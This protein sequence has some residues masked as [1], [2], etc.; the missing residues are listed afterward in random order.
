MQCDFTFLFGPKQ[1]WQKLFYFKSPLITVS[2]PL[3]K[4]DIYCQPKFEASIWLLRASGTYALSRL[5]FV[6]CY[7]LRLPTGGRSFASSFVFG[8]Q[9]LSLLVLQFFTKLALYCLNDRK[10][11]V[12]LSDPSR[13]ALLYISRPSFG[14]KFWWAQ[15]SGTLHPLWPSCLLG[16]PLDYN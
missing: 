6:L 15:I 13:T 1:L 14:P 16:N 12:R 3:R 10:P 8:Y 4:R 11:L 9:T 2:C 5:A 7:L